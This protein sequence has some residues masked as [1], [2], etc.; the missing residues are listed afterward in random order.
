[1]FNELL[2]RVS[3]DASSDKVQSPPLTNSK[4]AA[5]LPNIISSSPPPMDAPNF[6]HTTSKSKE[7]TSRNP[8]GIFESLQSQY[9][10][11][12][13]HDPSPTDSHPRN[14]PRVHTRRRSSRSS[15]TISAML[16]LATER[17][18]QETSRANEAER[19]SSEILS[20]LKIANYAKQRLEIDLQRSNN[21]L[22]LYKTQ[23]DNAQAGTLT[24]TVMKAL[25]FI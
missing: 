16:L 10:Q 3:S 1:M 25:R 11:Q 22:G 9:N 17:L 6:A 15:E 14:H 23:L 7:G 8:Q 4:E 5:L 12:Q 21:E 2:E 24:A 13:P 19:Q 18:A 20:H